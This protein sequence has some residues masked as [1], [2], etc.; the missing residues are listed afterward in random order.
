MI[1]GY[2]IKRIIYRMLI[3]ST[4]ELLE[5]FLLDLKFIASWHCLSVSSKG[6]STLLSSQLLQDV[7]VYDNTNQFHELGPFTVHFWLL[8]KFFQ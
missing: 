2:R 8:S 7:G 5:N 3:Q 1:P 6:H 4:Y